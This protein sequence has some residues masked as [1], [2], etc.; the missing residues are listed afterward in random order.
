MGFQ[1]ILE[2]SNNEC[3]KIKVAFELLNF[4]PNKTRCVANF[5]T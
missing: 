3:Q 5:L 4:S 1:I 2:S